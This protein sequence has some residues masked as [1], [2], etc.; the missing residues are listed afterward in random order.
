MIIIKDKIYISLTFIGRHVTDL[1]EMFTYKNPEYYKKK[2]M[3]FSTRLTPQTITNYYWA[4]VN[5]Q[6]VIVIPRGAKKKLNALFLKVGLPFIRMI[7]QRTIIDKK[8][9]FELNFEANELFTKLNDNQLKVVDALEPEGGLIQAPPGSGKTIAIFGLIA[10][11]KQPTL[12][13]VHTTVL[14]KQWLAELKEKTIGSYSIGALGDNKKITGDVTVAIVDSI[15][16]KCCPKDASADYSYLNKFGM[17][18]FDECH[19]LPAKSFKDIMDNAACKWKVGVTGTVA[20]KDNMQFLLLDS[21]GEVLVDIP[22]SECKDRITDFDFRMLDVNVPMTVPNRTFYSAKGK[23]SNIDFNKF[24]DLLITS[25]ARNKFIIDTV[26]EDI[27]LG[28]IPM[29]LTNRVEHATLLYNALSKTNKGYII[30]GKS[31]KSVKR[32]ELDEIKADANFKFLVANTEIGSEG[33]DLPLLSAL[34]TVMPTSNF[35]KI[36]Q[37]IA[38][39]RRVCTE[40]GL[41]PRVTDYVDNLA[42]VID[43]NGEEVPL[44]L[45]TAK[46]RCDFYRKLKKAYNL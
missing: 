28:Y 24:S 46:K 10:R 34:H 5:N 38:R 15:Y 6:K 7:D 8:I 13:V 37:Q 2:R 23:K 30:I 25:E 9:D 14:Q 3:G 35:P 17:I 11:V 43:E 1:C 36:K 31:N 19:H 12:I 22:E 18:V 32:T 27:R 33:L 29:I 26:N 44:F 20:R 45:Y 4:T 42:L 16:S 40:K 21:L 41:L 39:I